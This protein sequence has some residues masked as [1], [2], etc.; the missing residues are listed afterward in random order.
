VEQALEDLEEHNLSSQHSAQ[1]LEG[2]SLKDLEDKLKDL[3]GKPKDL[4]EPSLLDLDNKCNLLAVE[5]FKA[6]LQNLILTKNT[7]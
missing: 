4:V 2:D 5:G 3:E 6:K 1:A 7:R